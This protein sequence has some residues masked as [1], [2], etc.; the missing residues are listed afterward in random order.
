MKLEGF[1]IKITLS[2][3]LTICKHILIR[4]ENNYLVNIAYLLSYKYNKTQK[5]ESQSR[6]NFNQ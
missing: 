6:Q 1:I 4:K 5:K 3:F 2:V